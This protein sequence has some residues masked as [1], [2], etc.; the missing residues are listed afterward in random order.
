VTGAAAR[1]RAGLALAL[2]VPAP[3]IGGAAALIVSPGPIG[4]TVYIASKLWL[5]LLPACW[6]LAVERMPLSLSPARR[7][8]LRTGALLGLLI[9]GLIVGAYALFGRHLIDPALMRQAVEKAGWAGPLSYAGLSLYLIT[10]NSLMEEYVWRWFVFRQWQCLLRGA[11]SGTPAILLS[12][13]CFSIH[14]AIA[15]WPQLEPA[16]VILATAGVFTGG[17]LWSW[18]YLH[19]GS[20]WPG[21]LSH[22]I[23]DVAV[24]GVGAWMIF[25]A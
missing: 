4:T 9:S 12:A 18:L 19:F 11:A 8:G 7:G 23:V 5:L 15:L 2:L 25:G 17:A 10:A 13:L 21:Y 20:I 1:R 22:A 3:T 16:M 6:R 24:L 14:H